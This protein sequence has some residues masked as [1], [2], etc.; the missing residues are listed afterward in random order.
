M[1]VAVVSRNV[2]AL[3]RLPRCDDIPSEPLFELKSEDF[4]PACP[5]VRH[6]SVQEFLEPIDQQ[7]SAS[8]NIKEL[9]E[10]GF[11]LPLKSTE[12]PLRE[13]VVPKCQHIRVH[14]EFPLNLLSELAHD[15]HRLKQTSKRL[16]KPRRMTLHEFEVQGPWC[17]VFSLGF[18]VPVETNQ[19]FIR[20]AVFD[21]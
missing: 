8:L 17:T 2:F 11:T 10:P 1:H 12:T 5:L 3:H 19:E 21:I 13:Q 15:R 18:L 9:L 16:V 7:D 6:Y 14:S 4:L 20:N